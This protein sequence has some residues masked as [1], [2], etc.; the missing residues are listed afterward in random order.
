VGEVSI[1]SGFLPFVSEEKR[2]NF[3]EILERVMCMIKEDPLKIQ[4]AQDI[5]IYKAASLDILPVSRSLL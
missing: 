5:K 4:Q 2:E 1:S 3:E